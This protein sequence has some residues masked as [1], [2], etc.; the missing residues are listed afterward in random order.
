MTLQG[1]ATRPAAANQV[2]DE[3]ALP[4]TGCEH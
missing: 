3:A 2:M 4:V 1:N